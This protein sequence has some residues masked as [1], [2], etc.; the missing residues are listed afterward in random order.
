MA[1]KNNNKSLVG[2][3]LKTGIGTMVGIGMIGATAGMA[4]SLPAG[5][6]K[7]IVG[8]VPGLQATALVAHNIKLVK[9]R[10]RG[11]CGGKRKLDGSG[12]GIG[13][14]RQRKQFI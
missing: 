10:G 3:V 2:N 5:T 1:K 12:K 7:N 9:L 11:E 6:A 4:N 13:N 14:R 8:I